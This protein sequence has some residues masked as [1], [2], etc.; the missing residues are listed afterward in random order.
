MVD[1]MDLVRRLQ[2]AAPLRPEAYEQARTALRAAMAESGRSRRPAPGTAPGRAGRF[3]WARS[4]HGTVST[5]GKAGIGVGIGAI[6]AAAAAIALV[7]TPAPRP[8]A[9]GPAA[10]AAQAPATGSQLVSLASYIQASSG[11][12]TGD[13]SLIVKTQTIG[14]RSP[15]VLYELYADSGA[16]YAT[17]TEGALPAAIA[18]GGNLADGTAAREVATARAAAA[19]DLASARLRMINITPNYLGLG[20]SPAAQQKEWA[21]GL[22]AEREIYKEKG[23]KRAPKP[24]T[25]KSVQEEADNYLWINAVDALT[26]GGGNPQ[27]R[28]GVLRLISTISGVTVANSTSGGQPTLTLTAGPEVFGGVGSQVLTIAA[29]TGM[30]LKSVV[31]AGPGVPASVETYQVSRVTL[32]DIKAGKF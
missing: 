32:A 22:A 16:I 2:D 21:K 28:A 17:D 19:G 29:K 1:E 3:S 18:R 27:V 20:L 26:A 30:P 9:P 10:P 15:Y 13:A 12:Q 5:L 24:Y 23:V 25:A 31:D 6:A 14:D 7:A 4:P 11:H 8:A